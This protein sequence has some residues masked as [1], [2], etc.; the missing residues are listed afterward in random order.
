MR[1]SE[2]DV[3]TGINSEIHA[4]LRR[5]EDA[6]AISES[7]QAK[8]LGQV[9]DS[10][11]TTNS[12]VSK[13]RTEIHKLHE[14]L[15]PHIMGGDLC[16]FQN[17]NVGNLAVDNGATFSGRVSMN[18]SLYVKDSISTNGNVVVDAYFFKP[19]SVSVDGE[20]LYGG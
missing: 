11:N 16:L 10:L 13:L 4:S 14:Y 3:K 7:V 1:L 2:R 17:L 8:N 15:E 20:E 18:N 19:H 6:N 5:L 9:V 12:N